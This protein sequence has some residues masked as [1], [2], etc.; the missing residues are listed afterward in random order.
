V[1]HSEKLFQIA[2]VLDK[3]ANYETSELDALI[4]AADNVGKSWSGSWLS[5]ESTIYNRDFQPTDEV[6]KRGSEPQYGLYGARIGPDWQTYSFNS[7]QQY[8]NE[9]VGNPS[10]NRFSGD[11]KE[12]TKAFKR[13]KSS[14]LSFVYENFVTESDRFIQSWVG[15]IDGLEICAESDFIEFQRSLNQQASKDQNSSENK[16]NINM[17]RRR[18]NTLGIRVVTSQVDNLKAIEEDIKIP[19]H[20][21]ILAKALATR[22]PFDSCKAL[23]EQI[24]KLAHHIQNIEKTI[25]KK[26]GSEYQ[27]DMEDNIS[28][29]EANSDRIEPLG[30]SPDT[31]RTF[32][33]KVFIIHGRDDGVK[34]DVALFVRDLGLK[35][36]ILDRQPNE[37]LIAI[38]DKFEREAKK[39]DFAIALLTP[40]DVGALKDEAAEQLK[41]RARQNVIFELGYF[42]GKLGRKR[43]CLLLKGELENPSD[44]DGILYVSMNSPNGWKLELAREMKQA[45]LPIDP[46]KLL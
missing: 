10:I 28:S 9:K 23:N 1:S 38:L 22:H 14:A 20:I 37:G 26:D 46:E 3:Y 34:G 33:D 43:V 18:R 41:P 5:Y 44:L 39:A 32:G 42:I 21:T 27:T 31:P 16:P 12:A 30:E 8:I 2:S 45:G 6:Y 13:V 40:D 36:I 25:L 29:L 7:V 11:V 17:F 24:L 35:E 4:E 19:P 15:K